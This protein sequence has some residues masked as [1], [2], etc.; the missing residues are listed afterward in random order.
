MLRENK[1]KSYGAR[2]ENSNDRASDEEEGS[3]AKDSRVGLL[4]DTRALVCW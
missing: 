3:T 1:H 4:Q 2:I